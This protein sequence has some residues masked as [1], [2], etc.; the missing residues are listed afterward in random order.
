[1]AYEGG[2]ETPNLLWE[3]GKRGGSLS[4]RESFVFIG[5]GLNARRC[6]HEFSPG[7]GG[8]PGSSGPG[9][10]HRTPWVL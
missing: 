5:T 2:L 8:Q 4:W 10:S 7:E 9:N 6:H 1:M 3:A